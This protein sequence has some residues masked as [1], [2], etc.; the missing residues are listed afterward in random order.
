M[1]FNAILTKRTALGWAGMALIWATPES[2][3][4][5]LIDV[6]PSQDNSNQTLWIF[7]GSSA[8]NYGS[9]I[10]SS[11]NYHARDSWKLN[12]AHGVDV[13]FAN[14]PTNQLVSLF[15]LFSST[16][17]LIDIESVQTRIPSSF[18]ASA[19]NSPTMTAGISQ[20]KPSAVFL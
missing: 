12:A 1:R 17:N 15:P 18:S 2:Q 8:A 4:Q 7:S 5:L 9:S 6:Y 20:A 16:N 11:G 19:T 13:Y 14:Q 10:R 3:A